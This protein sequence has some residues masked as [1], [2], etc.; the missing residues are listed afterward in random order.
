MAMACYM[1]QSLVGPIDDMAAELGISRSDLMGW[2]ALHAINM[3]R[4]HRNQEPLTI[5]AYTDK[6]VTSALYRDALPLEED[7]TEQTM[8]EE[9]VMTG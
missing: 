4:S 6:V 3:V 5:P 2:A 8:Q 7:N 1:P 9:L